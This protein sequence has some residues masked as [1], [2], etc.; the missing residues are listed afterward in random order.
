MKRI[1]LSPE[2]ADGGSTVM[3]TETIEATG[4][5]TGE[6]LFNEAPEKVEEVKEEPEVKST[7]LTKED[8]TGILKDAGLGSQ[9]EE[10]VEATPKKELPQDELEKLFNVWKP[11][12]ELLA[13]LR[14]EKPEDAMAAL[15]AIRDGLLKQSMTMVE[16]RV[17]Q[18]LSKLQD[19]H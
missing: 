18:L 4:V 6:Q 17:Q 10:K 11:S 1:L 12:A 19:E 7:G 5:E 13:Q 14:S 2:G 15:V 8:I 9:R 16:H 3:G